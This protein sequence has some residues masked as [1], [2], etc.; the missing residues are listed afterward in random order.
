MKITDFSV[1]NPQFTVLVFLALSAVGLLAFWSIPRAEDPDPRF[2]G[3]TV[4]V[5]FPGANQNDLEQQVARPLE[6]AV[7]ELEGVTK[8]TTKIQDG[9]A[10]LNVDFEYGSDADKKYDELLRQV[11]SVRSQLPAEL[12]SIEV[13]RFRTTDVTLVQMALVSSE[14]SY[15]RL[16]ELAESLRKRCERV[17]GVRHSRKWAFPEK[18]VRVSLDLDRLAQLRL[19]IGRVLEAIAGDNL[20]LPGGAIELG[21]RRFN[22][23]TSGYYT[24]L[25]EVRATPLI[26][27]GR[28]IVQLG[29][30]AEVHWDYEDTEYFARFNRVPAVWVTATMKEGQ[31]IFA[32][33]AGLLAAAEEFRG[34]LPGDVRLEIGFDQSVNVSH[35]LGGLLRDFLIALALVLVTVLPLG[36][37][38]SLLVM[39]S[40]PLSLAI[41]LSLLHFTGYTL[42][43][44]SIVGLVIALGLLVDDS[45]VVVENIARFR[46]AGHAPIAAATLATQQI[47]VA[48]VGTTFTLLFAFLPLLALPGGPGMYIRSLPLAVVYTVLASLLVALT[49]MP[50]LASRVLTAHEA[51]EGNPLLR[52]LQA[53][54]HRTYRPLLHWCMHHRGRTLFF[55][56]VLFVASLGLV[57]VIGFSL[58][59]TAGIPQ[60]LVQVETPEG[61]SL[62]ATDIIVR[63]IE[64]RLAPWRFIRSVQTN[65]GRGNPQVYYNT[66]Q[67]N[68]RA[69]YAEILATLER[70]EAQQ[71]PRD[72]DA[73]RRCLESIPGATITVREFENGPPIAAPIEVRIFGDNLAGLAR[74]AAE[75]ET[76]LHDLPG[77][78]AVKNP[79]RIARTDLQLVID[80][81]KAALL[82][83]PLPEIDRVARLGV[84]GLTATRFI[85]ADGDGYGVRVMVPR[86]ER[87]DLTQ[88]SRLHVTNVAGAILPLAQVAS[89]EFSRSPNTISRFDRQRY[90]QVTARVLPGYNTGK[91]TAELAHRLRAIALPPGMR[92]EFGGEVESSKE[93]FSGIGSAIIVAIFGVFAVLVLEFRSFRGTLIVAS[94]IPLGVIGGL[95]ALYLT[96]YTLSFVATV[97]FIALIGIEIKNSILLV[98]FTN[99]LRERSVPL[100]EAIEQAG[101]IRFLPVVLTTL[102]ALGAL[103]PVALEGS[104]LFSPLAVVIIGGLISSLLLS[105]LVTPVMYSLIPPPGPEPVAAPAPSLSGSVVSPPQ[106]A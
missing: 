29:D 103:L 34:G 27:S 19:P 68:Q 78:T 31:N 33:R 12:Q 57:P 97:G 75:V 45:I 3:G 63:E 11:N 39:V 32:V 5:Q 77:T 82:G 36:L 69:N 9:V 51:P 21:P 14:A 94:V 18:Q 104:G 100:R 61:T 91:L 79:V 48:V 55:S 72:L 49:I 46:R 86:G 64:A 30:V 60:F 65:V 50:F 44:L 8:L 67:E 47:A 92:F 43:Q 66:P 10:V 7:K 2:P 96:G 53:L 16:A 99:Q 83:V 22:L 105:R 4:I 40:I 20:N 70:F 88:W 23:K 98:D 56:G 42:N 6:D 52:G 58:F 89:L 102:T 62:G 1:R 17:P 71:S 54:I 93:S 85:E 80:R 90:T 101:E 37:R 74:L 41:G 87:G 84:A 81:P 38:A 26:A 28:A 25:E 59:P 95:L 13:R 106:T 24:S 35:R 15:A 73:V 76:L